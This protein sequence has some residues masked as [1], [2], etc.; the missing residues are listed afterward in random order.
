MRAAVALL[1]LWPLAAQAEQMDGIFSSNAIGMQGVQ[2]PRGGGTAPGPATHL[3]VTAPATATSGLA[4][5]FS[6]VA[7]DASNN[8]A[9]GYTGTV[10]F[11]STD[12]AASLPANSALPG[13]IG[14][15]SAT[16]NTIGSQTITGTDTVTGTING[17]SAAIAV[18]AGGVCDLS[19]TCI[20]PGAGGL[21]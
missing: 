21:L 1:A 17:T 16:L 12:G 4:F 7:K 19:G 10:H 5:S 6:V 15:F 9:T 3:L 20:L 11:T 2:K 18:S 14:T 13:G 8:T